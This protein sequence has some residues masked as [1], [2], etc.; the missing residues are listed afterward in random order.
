MYPVTATIASASDLDP[1]AP[2]GP[3]RKSLPVDVRGV[4]ALSVFVALPVR[5]CG[6]VDADRP[7]HAPRRAVVRREVRR[8]HRGLDAG[9]GNG[10]RVRRGARRGPRLRRDRARR[11]VLCARPVGTAVAADQ[12]GHRGKREQASR[13]HWLHPV[14]AAAA[15]MAT[16]S[17][18]LGRIP[19]ASTRIAL[20][21]R[22]VATYPERIGTATGAPAAGSRMYIATRTRR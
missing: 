14:N 16:S 9:D 11:T 19:S 1:S 22:A 13:A 21:T 17:V 18:P 5:R 6:T 8:V 2:A 3:S 20:S 15:F 4:A 10:G 7:F 12:G